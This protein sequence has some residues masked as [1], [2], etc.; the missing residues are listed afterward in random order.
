MWSFPR[1]TALTVDAERESVPGA[2]PSCGAETVYRYAVMSDGGW[3]NV[4]KCTSCLVSSS[5]ERGPRF[6]NYTPRGY[7]S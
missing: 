7:V 1:P 6:G 4:V 2:C 3:W 5:R